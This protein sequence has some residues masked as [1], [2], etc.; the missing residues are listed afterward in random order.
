MK[1]AKAAFRKFLRLSGT[2]YRYHQLRYQH[3]YGDQYPFTPVFVSP[4][5]IEYVTG[6][7]NHRETGHLDYDPYFMPKTSSW[8]LANPTA[9]IDWG[10]EVDGDWDISTDSFEDIVA[11]RSI[12]RR[13]NENVDWSETKYYTLHKE[14][15]ESGNTTYCSSIPSLQKKC[16]RID[17]LYDSIKTDGYRSQAE[18]N[19]RPDHEIAVNI[20]RDGRILY[21]SEGRH[22]L[23]IAKVVG[24]DTVTVI[25]LAKHPESPPISQLDVDIR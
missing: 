10:T 22:R 20:A 21:N 2:Q 1:L 23:S 18:L 5:D 25:V 14:R 9:T 6:R 7:I 13:F 4:D 19:G 17:S 11:F 3:E 16:E 24:V 15:I 12:N 8:S